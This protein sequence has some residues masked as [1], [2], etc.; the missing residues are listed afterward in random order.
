MTTESGVA[1][2]TEAELYTATDSQAGE[3]VTMAG[4]AVAAA[5]ADS[6]ESWLG[7][8]VSDGLKLEHFKR[9]HDASS[10]V[11][12]M[13]IPF[14]AETATSPPTALSGRGRGAAEARPAKRAAALIKGAK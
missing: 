4:A 9:T 7:D 5:A 8:R 2:A 12:D 14:G 3:E 6:E 13:T 1:V 11:S 10:A